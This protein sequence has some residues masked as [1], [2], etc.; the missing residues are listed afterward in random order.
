MSAWKNLKIAVRL[1]LGIG[2]VLGLL[3]VIAGTA[4]FSLSGASDNFTAYRQLARET[5]TAASWNGDLAM[6]RF[7]N[8]VFLA[9]QTDEAAKQT[10]DSLDVLTD[11]VANEKAVFIEPEDVKAVADVEQGVLAF[12]AAFKKVV[13]LAKSANEP[14]DVM[15]EVG[16]KIE[17]NLMKIGNEAEASGSEDVS[18]SINRIMRSILML[19]LYKNKFENK[20]TTDNVEVFRKAAAEFAQNSTSVLSQISNP[21]WHSLAKEAFGMT[22]TYVESF[23]KY[24]TIALERVDVVDNT[25]VPLGN[26]ISGALQVLVDDAIA[27]QNELGPVASQNIGNGIVVAMIVSGIAILVG[28]AVGFVVALG[29]TRPVIAMTKA[30]GVLANGDM[31]VQIPAQGQRDEIGAMAKAV[32]VFKDNMIETDRLRA[33]QEETKKRAEE[34]R[35]QGML[36]MADRFESSVGGIVNGVTAAATEL[37][38]TAQALS[39]TAEETSRQSTAVAAASEQTTQ[40]VQTVAAATEELSS[41]IREIGNQV[42]ESTR[43]VAGA[44]TQAEDTNS[45]VK[46]LAE[47]AQKIGEVVTLINEI[48][49]QTN[50]LA[51]NATIEAARAGEAGK[52]FAVVASEVKN[53]ATQTGRATEEIAGQVKAIQDSTESAAQAIHAI[54]VTINRVNE[55]STAIASAVEEQGAATQEI[56]RNVQEASTGTAEVSTNITGVTQASQQT[57]AGSTQVLASASELASNG[58]RLKKEVDTFLHTVRAA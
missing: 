40:N 7:Y 10:L 22:Q 26:Q 23:E 29:I 56:S 11:G 32:Q 53:L 37:Q 8:R 5:A 28:V 16:P 19:R 46:G 24:Q 49:S 43:I 15:D 55:I 27:A 34:A 39:A 52:G 21:S 58:E 4:Y 57:S 9:Q 54:T 20:T 38:A 45:K 35:R 33:E 44:V 3:L 42:T 41:S 36:D 51:L 31:T 1:A 14:L 47:A 25:M 13:D 48:A 17:A 30:M 12:E 6:S 18:A 50:L 2:L